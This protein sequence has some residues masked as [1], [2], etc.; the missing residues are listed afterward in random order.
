VIKSGTSTQLLKFVLAGL[1]S[2]STDLA[3]YFLLSQV[4]PINISK[5]LSFVL[6]S[7]VAY[8]INKYWTFQQPKVSKWEIFRFALLYLFSFI[9]NVASNHLAL[10]FFGLPK[11]FAFVLATGL[12]A[13][14][15][16]LGQKFIVFKKQ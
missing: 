4:L 13:T 6:G 15:N 10:S 3:S 7:I 8:L 11:I 14:I 16:F 5:G 9:V 2:V 12:S 1:L